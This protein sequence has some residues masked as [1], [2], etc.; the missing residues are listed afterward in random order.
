MR[1]DGEYREEISIF[2]KSLNIQIESIAQSNHC[3]IIEFLG[4]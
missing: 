1:S 4:I 2:A 3:Q